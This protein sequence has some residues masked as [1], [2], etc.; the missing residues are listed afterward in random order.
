[1]SCAAP[2]VFISYSHDSARHQERVLGLADRL[3]A[4][5]IDAEIDQYN[6]APPEGWPLWCERQVAA[7][8]IVL[9]VCTE[10]YRRR[11]SGDE[12]PGR[13]LGV[14][15]EARIIRQL[16]Y[17]AGVLSHKFVPVL[18]SDGSLADIPTPIKGG[19]R[20]VIDSEDGYEELYRRLTG[21]PRLLRPALGEIRPL[22][23]RQ[24]QWPEGA[25]A[26]S[27]SPATATPASCSDDAAGAG[28]ATPPGPGRRIVLQDRDR[29]LWGWLGGGLV[30]LAGGVWAVATFLSSPAPPP[31]GAETHVEAPG[32]VAAGRDIS[33][34]TITVQPSAP[35]AGWG[36]GDPDPRA[37]R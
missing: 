16:L 2:K 17:D 28:P 25:T 20:Y 11:V 1:M 19:T 35:P 7:A 4:D 31:A 26:E 23:A 9:M 33:G 12:E 3:R 14:V 5:G 6:M 27:P 29:R 36:S 34:S 15:W 8:D 13:G 18:F 24:R 30:V 21:Q 32:G 37:G 22:P 10:T